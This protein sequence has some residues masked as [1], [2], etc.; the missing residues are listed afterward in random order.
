MR[1]EY[2]QFGCGFSAPRGWLNFDASPTLRFERLPVVGRLYTRN[3]QR[4]PVGVMY[5]DIVRGLPIRD[6][7]AQGIYC[8]HVLEHLALDEVDAAL[9]NVF[10]H[11]KPSG[12]FR[13]V[14]PDL[15]RLAGDYLAAKDPN[16]AQ[17]FM[18]DAA[19]GVKSRPRGFAI[20]QILLGN[21][22][23]LWMWD[24][25]SLGQKLREHGFRE[26]RRAAFG[27]AE[28][29]KFNEVE[30]VGRFAGCLAMQCRK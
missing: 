8:S 13:M 24:E 23:H 3:A 15:E 22:N 9:K 30:D 7:S 17:K 21:S 11:L 27:D 5:G 12:T 10:R 28:D 6:G 25:R 4:F 18:N 2:V 26:V 29:T 14:L 16:A 1:T 19:L 20:L